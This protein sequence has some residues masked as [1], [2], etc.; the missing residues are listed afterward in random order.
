MEMS[1]NT[2]FPQVE[3]PDAQDNSETQHTSR[4]DKR[5]LNLK[6]KVNACP[7]KT[8]CGYLFCYFPAYPE[9]LLLLQW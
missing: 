5:S 1:D 8:D 9:V 3:Y 7:L 6:L 2:I 4:K